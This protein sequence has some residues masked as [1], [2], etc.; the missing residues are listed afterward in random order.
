MHREARDIAKF[1]SKGDNLSGSSICSPV[2]KQ[3]T[4]YSKGVHPYRKEFVLLRANSFLQEWT[5]INK[6]DKMAPTYKKGKSEN[7]KIAFSLKCSSS[8]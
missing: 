5:P 1:V 8:P 2:K 3:K 6:G 7:G 4:P